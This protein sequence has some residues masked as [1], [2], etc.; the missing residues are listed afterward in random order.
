MT[1]TQD[2]LMAERIRGCGYALIAVMELLENRSE[3]IIHNRW[4]TRR[5]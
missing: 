5:A 4:A 2:R 3:Q 1:E